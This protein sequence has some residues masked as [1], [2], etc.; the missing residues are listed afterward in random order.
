MPMGHIRRI[1]TDRGFGF[2]IQEGSDGGDLFVH[3]TAMASDSVYRFN[4][5]NEGD[6]VSFDL[7]PSRTK[8][9]KFEARN[10]RVLH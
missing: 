7:E 9:G 5:L 1:N 8:P 4:D 2:I 10:V 3:A 6:R